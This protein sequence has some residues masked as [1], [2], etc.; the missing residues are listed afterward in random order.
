[1]CRELGWIKDD[2]SNR[3]QPYYLGHD[4][5][6]R[7][8]SLDINSENPP[9]LQQQREI[10][11]TEPWKIGC[12]WK[13]PLF[14]WNER[15]STL[16]RRIKAVKPRPEMSAG[17]PQRQGRELEDLR[18]RLCCLELH[19]IEASAEGLN[20]NNLPYLSKKTT[21]KLVTKLAAAWTASN[22]LADD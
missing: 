3:R 11:S 13:A 7:L 22:D 8:W 5:G 17:A 12:H 18:C 16:C 10:L 14:P 21:L 6:F 20:I 2:D 19:L 15:G 4:G 9:N 1:M